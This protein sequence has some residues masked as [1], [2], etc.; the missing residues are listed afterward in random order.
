MIVGPETPDD[1]AAIAHVVREAF[2]QDNE[3]RLVAERRRVDG[4]DPDL[5]LVAV[6]DERVVGHMLFSPVG[7]E[8]DSGEGVA[9]C[10]AP[11]AVLPAC[12]RQGIGSALIHQGLDACRQKGHRIAIV[13]GH[14]AYYPRFGFEA[15]S[16]HRLRYPFPCPDEV[17]MALA[18]VPGALEGVSG[19]VRFPPPFADV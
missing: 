5:S 8:G 7:I 4:F 18:L 11:V 1:Y 19:I 15:A 17:F 12:Q 14:P 13:V 3:A 2:G 9:P 6:R 10:L 16:R